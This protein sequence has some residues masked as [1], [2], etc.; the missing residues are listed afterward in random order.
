MSASPPLSR[1]SAETGAFFTGLGAK[2]GRGGV[3]KVD[4]I[5]TADGERDSVGLVGEVVNERWSTEFSG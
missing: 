1:T 4:R 5:E 2:A 3:E